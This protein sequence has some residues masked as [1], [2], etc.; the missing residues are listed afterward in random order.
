MQT[1]RAL[2]ADAYDADTAGEESSVASG[3]FLLAPPS[4][5]PFM[6]SIF[7]LCAVS[8]SIRCRLRSSRSAYYQGRESHFLPS[9]YYHRL[10][11][12][13]R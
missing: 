2:S 4:S 8:R 3:F 12:I 9:W 1:S 13:A 10:R 5:V 11:L 6:Y 7:R